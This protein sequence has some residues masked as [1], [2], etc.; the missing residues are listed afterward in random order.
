M[1]KEYKSLYVKCMLTRLGEDITTM[2]N[3]E[4]RDGW[5]LHSFQKQDDMVLVVLWR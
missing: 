2:L 3:T 1:V 4:L 5:Q